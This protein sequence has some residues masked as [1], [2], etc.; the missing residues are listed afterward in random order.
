MKK[1]IRLKEFDIYL[2]CTQR[3]QDIDISNFKDSLAAAFNIFFHRIDSPAIR[4]QADELFCGFFCSPSILLMDA[5]T[6]TVTINARFDE[7]S[8]EIQSLKYD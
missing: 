8:F 2:I 3:A 5:L 7:P 1:R 4:M 6:R